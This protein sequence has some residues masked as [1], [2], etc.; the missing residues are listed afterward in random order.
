[1]FFVPTTHR[2]RVRAGSL[3]LSCRR[4]FALTEGPGPTI[5]TVLTRS[6]F[7]PSQTVGNDLVESMELVTMRQIL[8]R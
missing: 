8:G 3:N 2:L 6:A 5:P 7:A 4:L 1:M